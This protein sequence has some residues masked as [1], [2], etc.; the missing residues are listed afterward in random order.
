MDVAAPRHS[1]LAITL[2]WITAVAVL[3]MLSVGL[4]MTGLP[5]GLLKLEVYA[6]HKWIGVAVLVLAAAR[7]LWRWRYAPPAL[8]GSLPFWER[9]V[10]KIAHWS[11]FALLLAMP[12]SGW[13]MNSASGIGLYWFGYI[14]VP[15]L[16]PSD[17]D[18]FAVLRIVH[19]IL[20][21]LLIAIVILHVAAVIYHDVFRRDG[22]F[23]RM[24]PTGGK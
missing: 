10:A 14:P 24:W 2:H 18:L 8:P 19:R 7:L 22:I 11:L 23:R 13:L 5:I 6:W 9:Q 20:S 3:G 17:P 12:I 16:V 15:D 21:R 4:W 1:R